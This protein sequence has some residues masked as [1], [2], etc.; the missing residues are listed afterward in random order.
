MKKSVK[1]ELVSC[2][3]ILVMTVVVLFSLFSVSFRYTATVEDPEAK[4]NVIDMMVAK[5][6]GASF[7]E[8]EGEI[9]A[10]NFND[11]IK[12]IRSN[13]SKIKD[14]LYEDENLDQYCYVYDFPI[15]ACYIVP[16]FMITSLVLLGID[17][18]LTLVA[19]V[20]LLICGKKE[21]LAQEDAGNGMLNF[22]KGIAWMPLMF[23]LLCFW[24]PKF[25]ANWAINQTIGEMGVYRLELTFE[26]VNYLIVA[27]VIL[28]VYFI[29]SFVINMVWGEA[30]S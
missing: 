20:S 6:I 22:C 2:I 18:L 14:G 8:T 24:F 17:C 26:S 3:F 23:Y 10:F 29:G 15:I 5:T 27:I 16:I 25:M 7:Q 4:V 30:D 28:A 11:S 12:E 9:T 13:L 21:Q 19:L 1:K